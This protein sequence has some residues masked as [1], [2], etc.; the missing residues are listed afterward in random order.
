MPQQPWRQTAPALGRAWSPAAP[1]AAAQAQV[2]VVAAAMEAV[3][4]AAQAQVEMAAAAMEAAAKETMEMAEAMMGASLRAPA[5]VA[6]RGRKVATRARAGLRCCRRCRCRRP[7][8]S[9]GFPRMVLATHG[10]RTRSRCRAPMAVASVEASR[11]LTGRRRGAPTWTLAMRR[12]GGLQAGCG[13]GTAGRWRS[14][15]SRSSRSRLALPGTITSSAPSWSPRICRPRCSSRGVA[16]REDP[17]RP[18]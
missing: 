3:A 2:E 11:A 4:A 13:W 7:H 8:P 6:T 5:L 18:P 17:T 1:T 14:A 9:V 10:P 15:W 12:A 16:P